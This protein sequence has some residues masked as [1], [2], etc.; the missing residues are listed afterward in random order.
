MLAVCA[1]TIEEARE[2]WSESDPELYAELEELHLVDAV[3]I[4]NRAGA[5]IVLVYRRANEE[6]GLHL[7]HY[8]LFVRAKAAIA[9]GMGYNESI[10]SDED[11]ADIVCKVFANEDLLNELTPPTNTRQ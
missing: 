4:A 1:G 3:L 10:E 11:Y 7:M 6:Q 5:S 9:I 2:Q 8:E